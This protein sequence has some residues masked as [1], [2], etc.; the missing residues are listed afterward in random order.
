MIPFLFSFEETIMRN[1]QI[2]S[3]IL[4]S[5]SIELDSLLE[6]TDKIE[7]A[8]DYEERYLL[9][10][11]SMNKIVLQKIVGEIPKNRNKKNSVRV[12]E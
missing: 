10:A 7:G 2:K 3:E 8:Y 5:V 6:D 9:F 12:Q 1:E 11:R 4:Q